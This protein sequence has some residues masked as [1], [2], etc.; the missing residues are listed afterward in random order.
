MIKDYRISSNIAI[1][2]PYATK[3]PILYRLNIIINNNSQDLNY[4]II[5]IKE[6]QSGKEAYTTM[7]N[8]HLGDNS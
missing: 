7:S 8:N 6:M 5:H 1:V 3:I 4:D 2:L